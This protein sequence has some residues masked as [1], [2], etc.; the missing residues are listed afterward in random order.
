MQNFYDR[1]FKSSGTF[2]KD[3]TT[4]TVPSLRASQL[5]IQRNGGVAAG[6]NHQGEMRYWIENP[7]K[8]QACSSES[9][10]ETVR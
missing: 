10:R 9:A 6:I 4:R 8:R 7:F 5:A 1:I 3:S 2:V